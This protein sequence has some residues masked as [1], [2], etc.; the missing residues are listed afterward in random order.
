M[1]GARC[2]RRGGGLLIEMGD[3]GSRQSK[4]VASRERGWE[5]RALN[6]RGR[7]EARVEDRFH[8]LGLE[9]AVHEG[10]QGPDLVEPPAL[11][12]ELEIALETLEIDGDRC[13]GGFVSPARRRVSNRFNLWWVL[14][15]NP[16]LKAHRRAGQGRKSQGR[17]SQEPPLPTVLVVAAV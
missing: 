17:E 8:Q 6:R 9:A 4:E 7:F 12:G 3:T 14:L 11:E 15:C 5:A 16:S 13:L 2:C 1:L 10:L